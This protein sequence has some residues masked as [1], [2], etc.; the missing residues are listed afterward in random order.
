[1]SP[2]KKTRVTMMPTIISLLASARRA[3]PCRMRLD[4]ARSVSAP[5]NLSR[6]PSRVC[7]CWSRSE[8]MLIPISSVSMTMR[9]V[10]SRRELVLPS[11]SVWA[12]RRWRWF[13]ASAVS[14]A[15]GW[16]A[17]RAPPRRSSR[18]ACTDV[19]KA[20]RASRK[21]FLRSVRVVLCVR[22]RVCISALV[23]P[24][25]E[26]ASRSICST[27]AWAF[28]SSF[29]ISAIEEFFS[30]PDTLGRREILVAM[31]PVAPLNSSS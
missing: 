25:E 12:R 26:R 14:S 24:V 6:V 17:R 8:R 2:M 4:R 23:S 21:L 7:R 28:A 29:S 19:G 27:R 18:W 11:A 31:M 9:C 20:A 30:P 22:A 16:P 3:M 13:C 1:M 10:C 5:L 15:E